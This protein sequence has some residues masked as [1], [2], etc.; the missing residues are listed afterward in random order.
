MQ[1]IEQVAACDRTLSWR[2]GLVLWRWR[3]RSLA[4]RLLGAAWY[5]LASTGLASAGLSAA[6]VLSPPTAVP[7][8]ERP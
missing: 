4:R 5:G 8:R 6:G 7:H 2:L 1:S 3:T